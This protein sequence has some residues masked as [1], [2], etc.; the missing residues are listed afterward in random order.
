MTRFDV[1]AAVKIQVK[2]FYVEMPCSVMVEYKHFGGPYCLQYIG[3]LPQHCMAS[4]P[5][6][7]CL[8]LMQTV[9]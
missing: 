8:E 3:I 4:Q 1:L 6:R 5:R 2:V 9:L 7:P